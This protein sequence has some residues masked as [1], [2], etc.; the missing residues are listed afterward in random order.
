MNEMFL[1]FRFCLFVDEDV[2]DKMYY[3]DLNLK[4]TCVGMFDDMS[5]YT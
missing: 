1:D 5:M 3:R 4:Q 2:G